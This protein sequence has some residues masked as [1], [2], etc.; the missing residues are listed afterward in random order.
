MKCETSKLHYTNT[1]EEKPENTFPP[2]FFFCQTKTQPDLVELVR[3]PTL[4][5]HVLFAD[6]CSYLSIKQFRV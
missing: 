3:L 6:T 2:I 1:R 5:V 4:D